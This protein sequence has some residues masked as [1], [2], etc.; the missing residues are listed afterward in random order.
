MNDIN[1]ALYQIK[2]RIK[3]HEIDGKTSNENEREKI[4]L[5]YINKL[6]ERID[7]LID[8]NDEKEDRINKAIEFVNEFIR[9]DYY[10]KL[11]EYIT[12]F[13]WNT[14]K[15]DLLNILQGSDKE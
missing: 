10:E 1:E 12:H 6:Q 9:E 13:T 14:T 4:I 8:K 5:N 2:Q 7:F 11:D 15:D 3:M